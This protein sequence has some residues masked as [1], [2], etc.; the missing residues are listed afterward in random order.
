MKSS[1][2]P[3]IVESLP[4]FGGKDEGFFEF[5]TVCTS[6]MSL[7]G[8]DVKLDFA[9]SAATDDEMSFVHFGEEDKKGLGISVKPCR[10]LDGRIPMHTWVSAREDLETQMHRSG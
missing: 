9:L 10:T 1:T 2:D 4:I 6:K 5:Y 3:M 7:L 8:V